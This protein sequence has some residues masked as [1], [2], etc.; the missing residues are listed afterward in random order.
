[1]SIKPTKV[2]LET[3]T[4]ELAKQFAGMKHLP[5]ERPLKAKRLKFFTDHIQNGTFI[6]PRWSIGI[7]RGTGE[8]YRLDG[9]HTSTA[10]AAVPPES[11]P[12]DLLVLIQTYEFDSIADDGFHM[13]D[14]FDHPGSVRGNPDAMVQFRAGTGSQELE[15][16]SSKFLAQA[17]NGI[18]VYNADQ[19]GG[20]YIQQ[21][22]SRGLYLFD[23]SN[24]QFVLWLKR[25]EDTKYPWI[26]QYPGIVAEIFTDWRDDPAMAKGAW[27][28]V[29]NE[30]SEDPEHES[31]DLLSKLIGMRVKRKRDQKA[32]RKTAQ[33]FWKRYRREQEL[34]TASAPASHLSENPAEQA[35]APA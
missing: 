7:E 31:R 21:A 8:K 34:D 25:F 33:R 3:L 23:K 30:S 11:F 16:L 1:M 20:W 5:G 32:I 17:T 22:R 9:Q 2:D 4:Q 26:L 28:L 13:F 14:M 24:E 10:L 27:D 6:M 35:G 18:A 29:F 12:K 15:A 19:E